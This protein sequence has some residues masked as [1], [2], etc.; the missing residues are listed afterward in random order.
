[1]KYMD[2]ILGGLGGQGILF[3]TKVMA[4]AAVNKGFRIMGAE[5]HGMAQRGGSVVSHLR[6]GDVQSTLVR[7]G[8]GDV[9]LA[10]EENEAYRNVPFLKAGG[11]LYA[12][13]S[14][15]TFPRK[16]AKSYLDR[17]GI[18]YRCTPASEI[19][20]E[21]GAPMATN[22]ALLGFFSAFHTDPV[23]YEELRATIEQISPE[24]Y[25]PVNL[26]VLEA[27]YQQATG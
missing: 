13:A 19:A 25:K 20:V 16:A 6:L 17:M 15:T 14:N 3:M 4:Y 11:Q 26:K 22:L 24:R 21:L 7:K 2:F 8:S 10:L 9:V 27:G 23:G 5:T 1:M 18:V 12:N